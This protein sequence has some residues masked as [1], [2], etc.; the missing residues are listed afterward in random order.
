MD[1]MQVCELAPLLKNIFKK[2]RESWEQ[3]R[4][5]AYITAQANCTKQLKPTDILKFDWDN[6]DEKETSISK[7]DIMR[8]KE[9]S[10]QF[11]NIL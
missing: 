5:I 1:K 4:M 9:K 2:N 3:T 6:I 8:L 11:L 10:K 7:E